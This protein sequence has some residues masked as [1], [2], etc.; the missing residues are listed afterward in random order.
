M[1]PL[2][3]T[4]FYKIDHK[5]QYPEGTTKIYSN[6]TAR[7]SRTELNGIIF[8][9][10]Q[11]F[12]QEYLIEDFD[13]NFFH[14]NKK[15]L[16]EEYKQFIK[17]TLMIEDFDASHIEALHDLKYLP[18]EIKAL[19]EGSFVP[20]GVPCLTITN[21]HP[22]FAWLVNYIET[23]M[24]CELWVSC[25]SA[26]TS[27]QYRKILDKYADISIDEKDK[28]LVDYQAHDF[29]FRGMGGLRSATLSGMGHLQFFKGTD[30]IPAILGMKKYYGAD[31]S[32]AGYG[33]V[34]ATEHSVMCA[35]GKENERETYRRLICDIYPKGIVSIVSDT[36]DLWNVL[37]NILPSLK[38]EIMARDGKVVIRPDCY[39]ED[40]S[41]LTNRG[42]VLFKDL[43]ETDLV[44]Q[45]LENECYEFVKP[46]KY[47]NQ[48]YEGKMIRFFDEKEK[49]DILVTPN[50]RMVFKKYGKT[51]I[52]EAKD[53]KFYSYKNIVR[54]AK[55]LDSQRELTAL[56]ALKIAFQAD[57]CYTTT[58][59]KI[60]FSFS[61][62]RKI[63]RLS[64]ILAELN[65]DY[66]LYSLSDG[67]YEFNINISSENFVKDFSWVDISRLDYNWCVEF[68]EELSYWD[69]TRRNV[70]RFTFSTTNQEVVNIVEIISLSA[71]YGCLVS[72]SQDNR[73][74]HFKDV[75]VANITKN[76][77]IGGQAIQKEE[78]DYNGL[79]YC[80]QVPTGK[81]VVK[82]KRGTLIC[83][84]SGNP[85]DIICGTC[86]A[87]S[88]QEE[89]LEERFL[90]MAQTNIISIDGKYYS[91]YKRK[92]ENKFSP[93]F[94]SES[95]FS[96]CEVM[97]EQKGVIEL[98][99]ETFG[100]YVNEKGY[101][102]LNPK[103]G[104]IYGDSITLERC[105]EICKRLTAKGFS[106]QNIV[107]GIGSYTYQYKTRDTYGFAMKSTYCEI[108][109]KPKNI[110]KD[111][112][113]KGDVSKKSAKGL[114]QVYKENG[115]Y[116]LKD[117]CKK[118]EEIKS[119]LK[120]I[121]G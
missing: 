85:V 121:Y 109:G 115:E 18:L 55:C 26:T 10:L 70:G 100:G 84:N 91:A 96:E 24:S 12:I 14:K 111:P 35:G 49:L 56:E 27:Y 92:S 107:F 45:V 13:K 25:T 6:F 72:K 20:C 21:T 105:E 40:T 116:K 5:R 99:W 112:I 73:Q 52:E 59:N 1:N 75:Y 117:E 68:I 23:L 88:T 93:N 32:K 4:D 69:A 101:K 113:T 119:E 110:F 19:P 114:L 33:S 64:S 82:R 60:R 47:I 30:T 65:V 63:D 38:D 103:I 15:E 44:A 77:E 95:S 22:D 50:H 31:L 87:Y 76:N 41:V 34:N 80:V 90:G 102:V 62:Q 3:K 54:S 43:K 53:T 66:K 9:G 36:W 48:K 79:V 106:T 37:T 17:D 57:G 74:E 46:T 120:R 98:L 83:G 2:L 118:E 51:G 29:S 97:A 28:W 39:S 58:G 67:K 42:W 61:K 104:A 8:F 71:G 89:Y 94:I 11:A 78:I 81:I 7:Q 86:E 16:V 108:N